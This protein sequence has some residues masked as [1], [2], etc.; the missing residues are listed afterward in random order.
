ML[1]KHDANSSNS[2]NQPIDNASQSNRARPLGS[3]LTKERRK[4]PRTPPERNLTSAPA[5]LKDYVPLIPGGVIE[6]L[7]L[8][9]QTLRGTS[10]RVASS[11]PSTA[12]AL[13]AASQ[14]AR[15]LGELG[16][17][18]TLDTPRPVT[19]AG[20]ENAT[21]EANRG[22]SPPVDNRRAK[23]QA[24]AMEEWGEDFIL[25]RDLPDFA[26]FL[27]K[28][29]K[30]QTV[31]WYGVH[32]SITR[33]EESWNL[34]R[35]LAEKC[36]AAVIAAAAY[37]APISIPQY[38]FYPSVDPLSERNRQLDPA[39]IE[40]VCAKYN[41]DRSRPTMSQISPFSRTFGQL[42]V[43]HAYRLAK[44]YVDFQLV[45]AGTANDDDPEAE[46]VVAQCLRAAAEDQDIKVVQLSSPL[47]LELNALERA[48]T[49]I[50]HTP[51]SEAFGVAVAEAL[52]KAKPVI[53]SAVGSISNQ[54]IQKFTGAL[55]HSVE[56]C[57][58][59]M[60]YL[61]THPEFAEGL[62]KNGREHVKEN[63]LITSDLKRWLVLFQL[64]RAT[65]VN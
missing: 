13:G 61:L 37:A 21:V 20:A 22:A 33:G 14:K 58:Y 2:S 40:K 30:E 52:W 7:E 29:K 39:F 8:L 3:S 24:G 51:T 17:T 31:I 34:L 12:E 23:K 4:K 5:T 25:L 16:I 15:L 27:L 44:R 53:A 64:L 65:P 43:I 18:V 38:V 49:V 45:L 10:V 26:S 54:V 48:A 60:R 1:E 19:E 28:R 11:K 6:E 35:P 9:A 46:L 59:Q 56:G 47:P 57:A 55:V 41:I 42:D 36:D 50:V 32:E 62:G 63:F